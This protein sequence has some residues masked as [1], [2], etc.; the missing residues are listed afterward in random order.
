LGYVGVKTPQPLPNALK[1]CTKKYK[2][3]QKYK[4]KQV[5][6]KIIVVPKGSSWSKELYIFI[7]KSKPSQQNESK[8]RK[9]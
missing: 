6:N 5:W 9:P 1:N 8:P 4:K 2:N 7:S 3:I